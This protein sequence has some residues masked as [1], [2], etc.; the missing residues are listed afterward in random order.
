MVI[1][2]I[3]LCNMHLMAQRELLSDKEPLEYVDPQPIRMSYN[4]FF[5]GDKVLTIDQ[6]EGILHTSAYAAHV[7]IESER[8]RHKGTLNTSL[9]AI[10]VLG[11]FAMY[12]GSRSQLNKKD[13]NVIDVVFSP[14]TAATGAFGVLVALTSTAIMTNGLVQIG[15]YK[16]RHV[17]AAK[18]YN[19]SIHDPLMKPSY[20]ALLQVTPTSNGVGLMYQF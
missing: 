8:Y 7:L 1:L 6:L 14:V 18:A 10:G 3:T 16:D 4:N 5:M 13:P 2:L 15:R 11:G 20:G 17:K 12:A 19:A 9:G